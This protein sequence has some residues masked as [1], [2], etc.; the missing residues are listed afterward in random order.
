MAGSI[1]P[2]AHI[3]TA[4]HDTKPVDAETADTEPTDC[5]ETPVS[6]RIV[7]IPETITGGALLEWTV[8]VENPTEQSIRPT[9]EYIAD[10]EPAGNITLTVDPGE[11]ERPFPA[12]YRT[13]P[14][15]EADTVTVRVEANGDA[16]ERTVRLRATDELDPELQFPDPELAVQPE[17]TVHFEVGA[18]D[19]DAFQTTTWWINGENVGDTLA[20]P[21]QGIYYAEQDAHY[22]QETF[23]TGEIDETDEVYE[24]YE[25]VAGIDV[26]GEQY[27][28]NWTITVTPTGLESPTIDA[29]RPEPGTLEISPEG[30]TLEIDV[31]DPDGSLERVVWWLSQADRL[32]G[33]SEVSGTSDTATLSVDSGRC[34]TCQLIPWVITG[35]GTVTV[36]PLWDVMVPGIDPDSADSLEL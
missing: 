12:S 36:E 15:P 27:R 1:V 5:E 32:L 7:E 31:T 20:A 25:V 17:T 24:T 26:D 35:D 13:E 23:E 19:P 33:V 34:H 28:A 14:V 6:V 18:V 4:T 8:E 9:I 29:A 16:D 11:T 3:G 22:W 10:G 2:A 21:W 30:T